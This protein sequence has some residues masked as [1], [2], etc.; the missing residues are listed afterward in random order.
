MCCLNYEHEYYEE[1]TNIMPRVGSEVKTPDGKGTVISNNALKQ[2]V[3]V[4]LPMPDGTFDART[5]I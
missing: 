2:L 4:K 5:S 1:I 3:K